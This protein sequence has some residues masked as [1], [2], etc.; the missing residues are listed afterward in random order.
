MQTKANET[1]VAEAMRNL[2]S[3]SM[4]SRRRN[5]LK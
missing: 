3:L 2:R 5:R 1:A 4:I